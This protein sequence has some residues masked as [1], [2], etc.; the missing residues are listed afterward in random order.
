MAVSVVE[1]FEQQVDA[2]H[3]RDA[4]RCVGDQMARGVSFGELDAWANAVAAELISRRG[5]RAEP[6]PLMVRAPELMLAAALGTL[7]AGKFYV[8]VNPMHPAPHVE[9]VL[10]ELDAPVLLCDRRGQT[11]AGTRLMASSLEEIIESHRCDG[12]LGLEFDETRLAYVLYTSGSTGRPRGIAQTRRDMLHNVARHRPLAIG[13]EDC[14][15][16]ISADGFVASV[17]NPFIALLGGAALAPYSFKDSGVERMID[18]LHAT[19]V[20][21][22]YGFPS[23]L[24]QLAA[25]EATRVYGDLRLAYLGGEAV[26]PTDLAAARRLFPAAALSVGLNSSETGLTCL[27]VVGPGSPIPDP[28]PAGRPVLDIEVAIVDENGVPLPPGSCGEIEISSEY[29]RPRHW[30]RGGI[31]DDGVRVPAPAFR[32]GDRGRI[33]ADG[34]VHHLGRVDQMVKIRGFRVE[35]SEVEAALSSLPGVVEVAVFGVGAPPETELAACIVARSADLDPVSVRGAV[36][37][38]LP[39]ALVPT[40]V[41]IVD[42]LP[43]TPNGKLDRKGLARLAFPQ[44]SGV[45]GTGV[46]L[47]EP[48]ARLHPAHAP[49]REAAERRIA[50]I[51]R[52]ELEVNRVAPDE[53]F[54]AL[55]GTSLTAVSVISRV[56]SAFGVLVPLVVLFRTPTVSALATAVIELQDKHAAEDG[57]ASRNVVVRSAQERELP[58]V[59]A[60]VNHYI[61]HTSFNFR[62]EPQTPGEWREDWSATRSGYP[63]LTASVDGVLAGV[64]YA[65]PWK[66]RAAY[67]WCAEVTVY[68]ANDSQRRGVGRALY[69]RL[70]RI[71]DSQ[72][73]RTQVAVITLPNPSSVALHEA[74]GFRHA[75]TLSGVGYKHGAWLDVGFWQRGEPQRDIPPA[76]IAAVPGE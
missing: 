60:L 20:T 10:D 54:F 40:R 73:Y 21:V 6:V 59:C 74:C 16:L 26:L 48:D 38:E 11:A 39:L 42:A 63:W 51:W 9:R 75:G 65:G 30:R 62:T 66:G 55:G 58:D 4:M 24:R 49:A 17:S 28:V 19:G 15:T 33:D 41:L 45:N 34:I 14:V 57:W 71:L 56:R 3:E 2:H 69:G 8:A 61:E 27:H 67:S 72:G 7:K 12:R 46:V 37:R 35:A 1:A 52:S 5:S 31:H 47:A 53:D 43:R 13:C 25:A 36:A 64:A 22:L 32:T 44:D 68:V 50:D 23:F 76:P 70:L 18:W 29:V